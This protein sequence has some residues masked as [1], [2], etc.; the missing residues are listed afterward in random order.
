MRGESDVI[1][2]IR[3]LLNYRLTVAELIGIAMILGAPY[4]IV[5][6]VWC[7][8]HSERIDQLQGLDLVL[9]YIAS[10]LLWPILLIADVRLA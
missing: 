7:S 4:L 9:S 10:I 6:V 2:T 1:D 3:R 8:G 5:G